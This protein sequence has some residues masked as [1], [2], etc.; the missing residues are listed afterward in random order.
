[1]RR[2][3]V[4]CAIAAGLGVA[5]PV[6]QAHGKPAQRDSLRILLVTS[7]AARGSMASVFAQVSPRNAS[8]LISVLTKSGP[9]AATGLEQK[10][11]VK[12]FVRWTWTIGPQSPAGNARIFVECGTK[13]VKTKL[14][15]TP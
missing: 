10:R 9:V 15:I 4:T 6:A 7:P 2:V 13:I 1:M 14:K 12:G 3:A 5:S 11:A 8:C